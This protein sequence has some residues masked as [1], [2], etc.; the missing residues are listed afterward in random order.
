MSEHEDQVRKLEE[1]RERTLLDIARLKEDL[2][3]EVEPASASDD[4]AA[5]DVAAD[6]YERGKIISLVRSLEIKV[7][8]LERAMELAR[9]G[10]YGICEKCGAT[11]PA[12]RLEIMPE[13]T[14]C[15][16]CASELEKGIGRS[17]LY[18]HA[19]E[20]RRHIR[21][22]DDEVDDDDADDYDQ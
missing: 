15:V 3:A 10:T 22:I 13:T 7:R 5:A 18:A 17:Q 1:L 4:D 19:Q 8:S 2:Q 9:Q 16:R 14:V 20:R 6:I 11:I 12:G 21:I